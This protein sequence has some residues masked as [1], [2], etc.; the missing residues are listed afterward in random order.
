MLPAWVHVSPLV[1]AGAWAPV[2]PPGAGWVRVHQSAR[3]WPGRI[4]LRG[5][6]LSGVG[7]GFAV[8]VGLDGQ[9]SLKNARDKSEPTE[10]L[11]T[12]GSK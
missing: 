5:D 10:K 9:G 4:G 1:K 3:R 11:P 8:A 7:W 6:P 12:D 2:S